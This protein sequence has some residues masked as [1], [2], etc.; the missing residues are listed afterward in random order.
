MIFTTT[1]ET[2]RWSGMTIW[3]FILNSIFMMMI[4]LWLF[5]ASIARVRPEW[6]ELPLHTVT[7]VWLTDWWWTQMPPVLR[8]VDGQSEGSSIW[9]RTFTRSKL[10]SSHL[11]TREWTG[12]DSGYIWLII[13]GGGE[14]EATKWPAG[15]LTI[16]TILLPHSPSVRPFVPG[17][18]FW[19]RIKI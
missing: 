12:G 10:I 18:C 2:E 17:L 14:G 8:L 7:V 5:Y 19:D 13:S 11:L 3:W 9:R 15:G 4:W 16:I 1:R 6:Q